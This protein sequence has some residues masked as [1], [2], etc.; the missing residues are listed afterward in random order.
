MAQLRRMEEDITVRDAVVIVIGPEGPRNFAAYWDE[1]Q[2]P[3]IGVPDPD[4]SVLKR[5]GQEVNLF[6]FGRMPGQILIDKG[7]TV[8]F[9]HYGKNM[10]DIPEVEEILSLLDQ[11]NQS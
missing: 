10:S 6:K 7:G 8:R 2:M 11:L 4:H 5:Y 1:H 9:V 3:F